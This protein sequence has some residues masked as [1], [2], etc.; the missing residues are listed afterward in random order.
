VNLRYP[1]QYYDAE[2]GLHYNWHRY[3]DPRIGRYITSDPIGLR[4]GLNTYAY[5]NNNPL[6]YIDIFG[7][8]PGTYE[9]LWGPTRGPTL[10]RFRL[11]LINQV[12]ECS[13]SMTK[14]LCHYFVMYQFRHLSNSL[15][16][17]ALL[18]RAP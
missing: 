3:Y 10:A 15:L 7:T 8:C 6:R 5:T 12:G 14:V 9:T 18:S 17:F 1:G 16:K 2:T 11:L 4:G 13:C